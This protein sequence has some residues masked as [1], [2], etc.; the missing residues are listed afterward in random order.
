MKSSKGLQVGLCRSK[1]GYLAVPE[2]DF[3][4]IPSGDVAWLN[5]FVVVLKE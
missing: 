3:I 4:R 2:T 5:V 1:H